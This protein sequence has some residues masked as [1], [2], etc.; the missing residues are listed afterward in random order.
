MR[1]KS[2]N[3]DTSNILKPKSGG[4]IKKAREKELDN[5]LSKFNNVIKII[6]YAATDFQLDRD[7]EDYMGFLNMGL[8]ITED[9]WHQPIMDFVYM[10][11]NGFA[12]TISVLLESIG[13]ALDG[14]PNEDEIV[15][16]DKAKLDQM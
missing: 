10:Y 15:I 1:A 14:V 2:I 4:E 8:D 7:E 12:D 9:Q 16:A 6:R 5:V 3:E 13:L 11:E